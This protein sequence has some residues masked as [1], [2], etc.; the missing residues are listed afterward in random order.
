[1]YYLE[2]LHPAGLALQGS[3]PLASVVLARRGKFTEHEHL[4]EG[5]RWFRVEWFACACLTLSLHAYFFSLTEA[6]TKLQFEPSG[7]CDHCCVVLDSSPRGHLGLRQSGR[8]AR[9]TRWA[10]T[11]TW[12]HVMADS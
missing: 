6:V 3:I 8:I 7:N 10:L 2:V 1:M 9:R 11:P 12:F 4:L 5:I